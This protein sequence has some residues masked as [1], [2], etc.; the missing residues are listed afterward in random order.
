MRLKTSCMTGPFGVLVLEQT[1]TR[2][3]IQWVQ[4]IEGLI[5]NKCLESFC[6]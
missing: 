5:R 1:L 3:E 4:V 2:P 6:D